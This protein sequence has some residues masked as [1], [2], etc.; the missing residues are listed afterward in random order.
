MAR[1]GASPAGPARTRCGWRAR[2][3][4]RSSTARARTPPGSRPPPCSARCGSR[5]STTP[6]RCRLGLELARRSAAAS[7]PGPGTEAAGFRAEAQAW[8]GT[9]SG[10]PDPAAWADAVAAWEAAGYAYPATQARAMHAHALLASGERD[11]ARA[12]TVRAFA[13][14]DEMGA[15][16]LAERV[17]AFARRARFPL[18]AAAGAPSALD[19]LTP[20]EREVLALLADGASNRVIAEQARDQPEDG[21]RARVEPARQA[22]R[23]QPARGGRDRA[24]RR[25][26]H[27]QTERVDLPAPA[28]VVLV[29][30]GASGKSTWAAEHFAPGRRR[31]QRRPARAGRR[32]AGRHLR[33]RG[34]LR[35]ARRRRAPAGRR[36][37]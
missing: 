11:A 10:T 29:G 36:A 30:P 8:T 37:A 1:A 4:P 21:R 17:G 19:V 16:W 9:A 18:Q 32:R 6:R 14:A 24:P 27:R 13:D 28:L 26:W 5:T 34:R 22:R 33:E 25:G 31:V 3:R 12:Q 20:R 23:Q 7:T 15:R 2:W 35:A